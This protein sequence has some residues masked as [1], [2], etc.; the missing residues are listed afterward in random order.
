MRPHRIV[1]GR[2][3]PI[4]CRHLGWDHM[5]LISP[6]VPFRGVIGPPLVMMFGDPERVSAHTARS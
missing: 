6:P 2:A 4:A 5:A 3:A 1:R